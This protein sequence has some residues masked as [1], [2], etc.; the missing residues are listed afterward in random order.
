M[1]LLQQVTEMNPS[2]KKITLE[3]TVYRSKCFGFL[4]VENRV[5]EPKPNWY[6]LYKDILSKRVYNIF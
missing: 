4:V 2:Q 3:K 5:F 1:F 6:C